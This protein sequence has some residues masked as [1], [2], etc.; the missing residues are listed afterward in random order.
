MANEFFTLRIFQQETFKLYEDSL[1]IVY[2]EWFFTRKFPSIYKS[3]LK[4]KFTRP[5]TFNVIILKGMR[6]LCCISES[7]SPPAD[8]SGSK[9]D[10]L[11]NYEKVRKQRKFV[12]K[13]YIFYKCS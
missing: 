5:V 4:H 8:I 12:I 9:R 10:I 11:Q 1:E 7:D 13:V 6:N 3:I 2:E